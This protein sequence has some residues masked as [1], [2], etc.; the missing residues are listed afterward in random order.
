[1]KGTASMYAEGET[2]LLNTPLNNKW[3]MPTEEPTL[4]PF[5]GFFWKQVK[6]VDPVENLLKVNA[7]NKNLSIL[8]NQTEQAEDTVTV[9]LVPDEN[10]L[11][12]LS[13]SLPPQ[14][15]GAELK[16]IKQLF[17]ISKS[18]F[19]VTRYE[20]RATVSFFGFKTMDFKTVSIPTDYDKTNIEM[21]QQ[22]TD[23]LNQI[24]TP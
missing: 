23:K 20:V 3:E 9:Q 6:L 7:G 16:D 11:S 17:W 18:D 1:M 2:V 5:M 15:I 21:P 13:K 4:K 22:L 10:A 14:L 24:K 12:E 8:T 19:L